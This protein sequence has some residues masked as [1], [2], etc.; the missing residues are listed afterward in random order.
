M[1]PMRTLRAARGVQKRLGQ[2]CGRGFAVGA[3]DACSGERALGVAKE[4]RGSLGE[5]AAAVLDVKNGYSW[6]VDGEMVEGLRGVGED[7]QRA[8]GDGLLDVAIAVCRA[9]FH[10]H[11]DRAGPDAARVVLDAGDG[12]GRAA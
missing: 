3:R 9:A 2:K 10:G 5:R 6:L 8:R 12:R 1:V 7:A 11:E 4:S